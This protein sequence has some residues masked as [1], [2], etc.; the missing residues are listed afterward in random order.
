MELYTT[1]ELLGVI[2][3]VAPQTSFWLP[4]FY[5]SVKNFETEEIFFDKISHQRTLA[6]FVAPN[7]QGKPSYRR[8]YTTN[9]LKPA[10]IKPK[11]P[12][13]PNQMFTR[14]AGESLGMGSLSPSERWDASVAAIL[15]EHRR[16]IERRWEWMAAQA[17]LYG[18]VT[19]AGEDYPSVTVDFGRDADHTIT[20]SGAALWNASADVDIIGDIEDWAALIFDKTGY[21]ISDVFVSPDVWKVMKNN[22][23]VKALLESRRGS[24]STAEV[25]PLNAELVKHVATL[26]EFEI[27]TYSDTYVD[28]NDVAQKFMPAGSVFMGNAQGVQG[29]QAFGAILD[30][31][32]DLHAMSIFSKMWEEED[33][34]ATQ[35]MSQS[36]PLMV[37]R[38]PN[39]TVY[40]KVL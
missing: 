16:M 35:I 32:A 36:A 38:N 29:I 11:D 27:W 15:A 8:G 18:K 25:G 10:Y 22:N 33:P 40:A 5:T 17:T 13:L 28:D 2:D 19:M 23:G 39:A 21:L 30:K 1:S 7:V 34:P 24:K 26:G 14:R 31:K 4:R 12:V 9:V 20:L 37:P 3:T 6:P